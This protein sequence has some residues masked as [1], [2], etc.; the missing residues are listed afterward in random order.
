MDLHW[1][2]YDLSTDLGGARRL[3]VHGL[4]T[5]G[6]EVWVADDTEYFVSGGNDA[7]AVN[8]TLT[9]LNDDDVHVAIVVT[10]TNGTAEAV[11]NLVR[12]LAQGHAVPGYAPPPIPHL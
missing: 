10:S 12:E 1:G 7:V 4:E 8:F 5:A 3:T 2:A 11:R 9:Q 6:L